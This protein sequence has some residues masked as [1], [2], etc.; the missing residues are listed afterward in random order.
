MSD[1]NFYQILGVSHSASVDEIKAAYRELV[2]KYHPDLFF[3][4][5]EKA[6]ATEKLR[7]INEAYAVVGDPKRRERYDRRFIHNPTENLRARARQRRRGTAHLRPAVVRRRVDAIQVFRGALQFSKK[8][9]AYMLGAAVLLLTVVYASRSEPR[10]IVVYSLFEKLEVTAPNNVSRSENAGHGWV[11][12]GQYPSI[13]ECAAK[14]KEKV[15]IDEQEGGQAVLG[16]PKGTMAITM[17]VARKT[18][19]NR[20][21]SIVAKPDGSET[22]ESIS[23]QVGQPTEERAESATTQMTKTVRNLE[24][25]ATQRLISESWLSRLTQ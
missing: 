18:L 17:R 16:D 6:E 1:S 12:V 2:K 11:A 8:R 4:A 3:T 14:L 7:V 15:R 25:R 19:Q 21:N 23:P 20:D 9:V 24:C 13:S 5:D 10:L 22:N